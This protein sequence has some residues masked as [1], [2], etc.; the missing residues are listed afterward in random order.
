MVPLEHIWFTYFSVPCIS[1][2]QQGVSIA[3]RPLIQVLF[4]QKSRVKY[5]RFG[6]DCWKHPLESHSASRG[7]HPKMFG[8]NSYVLSKQNPWAV[9]YRLG[10]KSASKPAKGCGK[11]ILQLRGSSGSSNASHRPILVTRTIKKLEAWDHC[12]V[13]PSLYSTFKFH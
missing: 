1:S 8:I 4:F 6:V 12:T 7:R 2:S 10:R 5:R 3:T 9:S 13:H 11:C